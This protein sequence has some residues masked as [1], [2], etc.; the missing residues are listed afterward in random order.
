MKYIKNTLAFFVFATGLVA[1]SS[2]HDNLQ[3]YGNYPQDG[4]V[5][6]SSMTEKAFSRASAEN[7]WDFVWNMVPV[8]NTIPV[9]CV[10]IM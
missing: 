3:E 2:E 4:V 5:R 1:C 7:H 8:I 6:V 9:S 10:G